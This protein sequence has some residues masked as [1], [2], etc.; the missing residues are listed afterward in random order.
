SYT[1]KRYYTLRCRSVNWHRTCI[2]SLGEK[3]APS[4]CAS[5][6][7]RDATEP[8]TSDHGHKTPPLLGGDPGGVCDL[9]LSLSMATAA[10]GRRARAAPR[11]LVPARCVAMAASDGSRFV[12]RDGHRPRAGL[13]P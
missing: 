6:E 11:G 10:A 1:I 4:T 2:S 3:N 9:V 5:K 7:A 8:Q 12:A 13:V